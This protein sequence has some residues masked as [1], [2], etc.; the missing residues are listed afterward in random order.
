M[1]SFMS[2][3]PEALVNTTEE[4][5]KRVLDGSYAFLWDSA[6]NDYYIKRS[7]DLMQI[8]GLLDSSSYG[9]ATQ[10]G[11]YISASH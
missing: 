1:Y 10:Q 2:T 9:F 8:G 4:G 5:M 7:C 6:V 3:T 11:K